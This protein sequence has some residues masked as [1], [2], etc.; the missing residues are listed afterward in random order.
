MAAQARRDVVAARVGD[1]LVVYDGERRRAHSLSSLAA[2]VFDL[3][4]G[5][6]S[7]QALARLAG[8]RI[9]RP[10]SVADVADALAQLEAGGLLEGRP[11]G[12]SRRAMMRKVAVAGAAG[13]VGA[14]LI[15]SIALP[16]PAQADSTCPPIGPGAPCV[17]NCNCGGACCCVGIAPFNIC[18]TSADFCTPAGGHCVGP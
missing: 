3:A 17:A 8:E 18:V 4:D 9:G 14:S 12:M 6:H 7:D 15:T 2:E 16:N 13:T 10:V 1:E 11:G 5:M